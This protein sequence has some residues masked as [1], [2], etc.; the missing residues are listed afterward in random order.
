VDRII[1]SRRGGVLVVTDSRGAGFTITKRS[2][3]QASRGVQELLFGNRFDAVVDRLERTGIMRAS[4][5]P[6]SLT[7]K[8]KRHCGVDELVLLAAGRFH[9][10]M[11]HHVR[12]LEQIGIA[13]YSGEAPG[14]AIFLA[15]LAATVVGAGGM[16]VCCPIGN[17][18]CCIGAILLFIVGVLMMVFVVEVA[19]AE[20]DPLFGSDPAVGIETHGN[21]GSPEPSL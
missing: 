10:R 13:R 16:L 12:Q 11:N 8:E 20:G 18:D 19:A 15:G 14:V 3:I 5:A 4:Y 9:A 6:A 21:P 17:T 7:G 1:E 2:G